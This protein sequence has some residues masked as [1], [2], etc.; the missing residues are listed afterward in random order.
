MTTQYV[1]FTLEGRLYGI[2]VDHVQE[3]LPAR[4]L[5]PV[6]LAP[7]SVAGL[8]NLRGSV[9]LSVDLRRRLD[10]AEVDQSAQ[11]MVVVQVHGEAISLLVDEIGGVVEVEEDQF[12]S[13]PPTLPASLRAVIDG[14]YKL[15][16]RLLLALDV[17]AAT[18]AA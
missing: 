7:S 13:P 18:T 14:A 9:V 6:P 12:E 17:H 15:P 1:T 11:M 8:V 2:S 16:G 4:P 3:V 10:L 5:T